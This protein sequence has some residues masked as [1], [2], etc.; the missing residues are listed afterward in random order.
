MDHIT[1][2][3]AGPYAITTDGNRYYA[4]GKQAFPVPTPKGA[5]V[6]VALM[7]D[8]GC[9]GANGKRDLVGLTAVQVQVHTDAVA[10]FRAAAA[11]RAAA[12]PVSAV[13]AFDRADMEFNA[14]FE[15][16]LHTG[17]FD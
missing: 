17:R 14:R 4:N 13:V 3:Q 2:R 7:L 1:I 6:T 16:G 8:T 9:T 12:T 15:R 10:A 11:E 5:P